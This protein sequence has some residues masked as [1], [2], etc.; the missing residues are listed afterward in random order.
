VNE[1]VELARADYKRNDWG[2]PRNATK[3]GMG[4][5]FS[6]S[7][8]HRKMSRD[9]RK[10]KL[11]RDGAANERSFYARFPGARRLNGSALEA[12]IASGPPDEPA[13]RVR[14]IATDATDASA[15][16]DF[17]RRFPGAARITS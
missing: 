2:M 7:N 11:G 5:R 13:R 4:G 6:E 10:L 1:A 15:A 8:D 3:G 16:A 14:R 12:G 9:V 17:Y